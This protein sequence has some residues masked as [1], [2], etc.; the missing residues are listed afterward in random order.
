MKQIAVIGLGKFGVSLATAYSK[1]GGTVLAIDIDGDKV[2]EIADIVT[3]AVKADVS[4]PEVVR[5]VGLENVDTAVVAIS[6]N[7]EASVMATILAKELGVP[8]VI[9]KAQNDV[10][11]KVLTK[12]GA[13]KIIFP[14]K[15]MGIKLAKGL[16]LTHFKD[17]IDLKDDYSIVE[18]ATP[19]SWVGKNLTEINPRK[20]YGFNVIAVRNEDKIKVNL[21]PLESF[22]KEDTLIVI[23]RN[24]VMAKV[25]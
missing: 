5:N 18:A 3:Y 6:D 11:A 24:E 19:K 25:F 13:D 8:E 16:S 9:A 14:E 1:E 7:L 20:K 17:I 15:D 23:G 21:D 12:V 10:H 2:Q 4:D 22:K